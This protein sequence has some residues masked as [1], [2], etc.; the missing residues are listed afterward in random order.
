MGKFKKGDRVRVIPHTYNDDNI[1]VGALGTVQDH[2]EMPFV[3]MDDDS[4]NV[5]L[6]SIS[7]EDYPVKGVVF[8][9]DELE[10]V[11]NEARFIFELKKGDIVFMKGRGEVEVVSVGRHRIGLK[12]DISRIGIVFACDKAPLS[13]IGLTFYYRG[14]ING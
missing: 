10:I 13:A 2:S 4:L 8:F 6:T 9:Q 12:S 7:A 1:P 14:L 3:V 11:E 5:D